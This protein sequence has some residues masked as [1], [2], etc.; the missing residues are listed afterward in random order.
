[1]QYKDY[2]SILGIDK[3]ATQDDVKKAYRK[4]AKK[5]HPDANP[6]DKKAEDKFKEVNEAYEV[7]GDAGKRKK[8][9]TF[10]SEV[11]FQNGYDFDPSQYGF[12]NNVRYEYSAGSGENY[13]DFFNSFFG[14]GGFD[15]GSIFGGAGTN[16]RRQN[17]AAKG[18]D[19]EAVIEILPE[20]GFSGIEKSVSIRGRTGDK[21][22]SFRVP[23]GVRDGEKIRLKGQGEPGTNGGV[24]GDLY[25]V[26]KFKKEADLKLMGK[27]Y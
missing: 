20:E 24:K 10:G 4:L 9:D 23:K 11:N 17:Y 27:I 5:Y 18:E 1:M 15:L 2:Y 16:R 6:N 26:V 8:Y 21:N 14:G 7:L 3:N 19:I 13:S 22:L 12:G 25:L